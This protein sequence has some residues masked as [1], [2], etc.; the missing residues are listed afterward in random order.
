MLSLNNTLMQLL[1]NK[2]ADYY[3]GTTQKFKMEKKIASF[4][5]DGTLI[6]PKSKKKFATDS[7]DW[8]WAFET[9]PDKLKKLYNDGYSIV[10]VSNQAGIADGK[11]SGDA[12]IEKLNA[13]VKELDIEMKVFCS[14]SKNKYRKPLPTFREEFFPEIT[15]K[16]SFYCGDAVGRKGD[17]SDTDYKFAINAKLNFYTPEHLFLGQKNELPDLEYC[18]DLNNRNQNK[19]FD[20]KPI[21]K[22]MLIMVG[23]PGSGKSYISNQIKIKHGYEIINQDTLK[24]KERCIKEAVK[25]MKNGN[26]IIIDSTNPSKEK[27]KEWIDLAKDNGY[28]VRIILMKTR[29]EQSKHNNIYRSLIN[30]EDREIVPDIAYNMYKSKFEKPELSEGIE[31]IKE[32]IEQTQN[33]PD[34]VKYWQYLH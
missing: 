12:W 33:F 14:T 4:D 18:I 19:N 17:F 3:E 1:W 20:F 2:K 15:N 31:E 9:V 7:S 11:Q 16:E 6:A 30:N 22:E 13:I 21:D 28:S 25:L 27:R 23:Y 24:T 8:M 26:Q 29:I 34:D 32:I 5:L 10:V